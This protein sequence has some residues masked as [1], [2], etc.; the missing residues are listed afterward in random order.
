M[1][2]CVMIRKTIRRDAFKER[3]LEEYRRSRMKRKRLG[4]SEESED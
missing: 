1:I 4:V 2:D 3:A